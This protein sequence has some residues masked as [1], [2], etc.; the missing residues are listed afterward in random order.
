MTLRGEVVA[1]AAASERRAWSTSSLRGRLLVLSGL[2][3]LG[4]AVAGVA[5]LST[6]RAQHE[7]LTQ[8]E[9]LVR[10]SAAQGTL[11]ARYVDEETA[12]RGYL[13][14]GRQEFLRPYD[15][16]QAA[17]PGLTDVLQTR[18][19][20]TPE[21]VAK[22]RALTDAYRQ[23]QDLVLQPELSA[24]A[25]G[26]LAQARAREG[27]GQGKELFDA[28]RASAAD[29]SDELQTRSVSAGDRAA[30]LS[31]RQTQLLEAALLGL[32][33]LAGT[34]LL[35][36]LRLVLAPLLRLSHDVRRVS[37]GELDHP[38]AAGGPRELA[39]LGRDAEAMRVR[40]LSELE[41]VR[42]GREALAQ[43]GPAVVALQAALAPAP[44]QVPHL[45][46]AYRLEPAEGMLAGDWLDTLVLPGQRL[47]VV[48][49]DVSGHGAGPAVFALRL[50]HLIAAALTSGRGPGDSMA[51]TA[52][53]LGD[54]GELFATV[55]I[56]VLD[57][58]AG[59]LTYA[60]A[61]HPDALLLHCAPGDACAPPTPHTLL[62]PTG[63][64]LSSLV[65][66]WGWGE[67][68]QIFEDG[69]VL[70]GYTD[71]LVEARDRAGRQ[72]GVAGLLRSL[73]SPA[74]DLT[75]MLDLAIH[76]VR[77]FT[78]ERLTDDCTLVACQRTIRGTASV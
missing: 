4:V 8:Q 17:I 34:Q 20:G 62:S 11:L 27:S 50:K 71:G 60:N 19:A 18:T 67:Q 15:Q 33:V 12:L 37:G 48:L 72:F 66:E 49:G 58:A 25:T 13:L 9:D 70:L 77:T 53:H 36:A 69:D 31:A 23:W 54:T 47:G 75:G 28:I 38:V 22:V 5:L 63:P 41:Q 52:R 43:H 39:A 74:T 14:S 78:G 57:A 76:D 2:V 42:R 3:L 65:A 40:L 55:F 32:V 44:V 26:D 61:G 68:E 21:L 24:A 46:L 10:A 29:L 73:T 6:S 59:R 16:A 51:W 45:A 35:G 1:P 7:A 30:E 56:A 64:L